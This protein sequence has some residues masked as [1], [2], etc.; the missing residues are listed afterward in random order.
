[1]G[2]GQRVQPSISDIGQALSLVTTRWARRP[3]RSSIRRADFFTTRELEGAATVKSP[4]LAAPSG[5]GFLLLRAR[6]GAP[7][8]QPQNSPRALRHPL[9]LT[10]RLPR[11]L[12]KSRRETGR[13]F[14]MFS[15]SRKRRKSRKS[16]REQRRPSRG[17]PCAACIGKLSKNNVRGAFS[18]TG[19]AP[20]GMA[21]VR[22]LP[23]G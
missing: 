7:I 14:C 1:M 6:R 20:G 5:E 19:R 4:F 21:R 16:H 12:E 15:D 3:G 10:L 23:P 17:D 9:R 13:E 8:K 18:L 11:S 22:P 2:A